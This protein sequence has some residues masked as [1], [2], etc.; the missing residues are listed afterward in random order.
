MERP[1]VF[2]AKRYYG[3]LFHCNIYHSAS[4]LNGME[5]IGDQ[6]HGDL[7]YLRG[8]CGNHATIAVDMA[9]DF[10]IFGYRRLGQFQRFFQDR[11]NPDGQFLGI[12]L[13]TE[14]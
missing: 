9:C 5:R 13:T 4:L 1:L 8:I 14:R 2:F 6:V 12:G 10:N 7:M 3:R 11:L